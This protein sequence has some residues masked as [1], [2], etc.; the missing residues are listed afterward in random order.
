MDKG[1]RICLRLQ[2]H[3]VQFRDVTIFD[4]HLAELFIHYYPY[5]GLDDL[6]LSFARTQDLIV[7][8]VWKFR[9]AIGKHGSSV[10]D[11]AS[12]GYFYGLHFHC[13]RWVLGR[14]ISQDA[15]SE[16]FERDPSYTTYAH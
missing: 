14:F 13:P 9:E 11:L 16:G 4:A 12:F 3:G 15:I 5:W 1:D 7:H 6:S 8:S 10:E 2:N